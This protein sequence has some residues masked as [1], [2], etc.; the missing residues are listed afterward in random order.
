MLFPFVYSQAFIPLKVF[1]CRLRLY[2]EKNYEGIR[3]C[4]DVFRVSKYYCSGGLRTRSRYLV[5]DIPFHLSCSDLQPGQF[6]GI[7]KACQRAREIA[8]RS[9]SEANIC[10][11]HFDSADLGKLQYE[12]PSCN[13]FGVKY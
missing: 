3:I 12:T 11:K 13:A 4:L 9:V 6:T 10:C 1:P 5:H 2:S 7:D 8:D